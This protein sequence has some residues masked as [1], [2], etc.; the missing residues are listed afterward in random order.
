MMLA[1]A[2]NNISASRPP[3]STVLLSAR[4]GFPPPSSRAVLMALRPNRLRTGV[5][6]SMMSKYSS[7]PR[8]QRKMLSG[9]HCQ[10]EFHRIAASA[11]PV[12]EPAISAVQ[13]L[14]GGGVHTLGQEGLDRCHVLGTLAPSRLDIL[15]E[16]IP[17][18]AQRSPVTELR[19][20][21]MII[22]WGHSEPE[23]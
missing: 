12:D 20:V 8:H 4:T 1:P 19:R 7:Q 10:L 6:T 3:P 22:V 9:V 17:L 11:L 18:G 14:A 2:W 23:A 15:T 5:P 13:R 21:V 16:G